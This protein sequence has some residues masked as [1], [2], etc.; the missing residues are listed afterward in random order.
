MYSE[1]MGLLTSF[2]VFMGF[3][4]TFLPQFLLGNAGMPRRYFSYPD[5]YQWLNVLSSGGAF[6]LA[7]ALA[8]T[9][10]NLL[11]SL[12]WGKRAGRNPW[13]SRSFE[14]LAPTLPPKHNFAVTPIFGRGPYDYQ[15]EED[16][17]VQAA[18]R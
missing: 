7:G 1:R 8:L 14:W 18:P 11:V 12:R 2:G 4:L 13:G 9:L 6:L 10:V 17:H 15:L 5:R 16:S 3:V